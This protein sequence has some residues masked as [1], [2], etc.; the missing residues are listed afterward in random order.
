MSRRMFAG[1]GK[2]TLHF[3]ALLRNLVGCITGTLK[4]ILDRAYK[5]AKLIKIVEKGYGNDL[6][7]GVR[8]TIFS[9]MKKKN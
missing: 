8:W 1:F 4:G 2:S 3:L 9:V 5:R 6:S 7:K